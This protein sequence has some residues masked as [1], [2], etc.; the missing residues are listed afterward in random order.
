[1]KGKSKLFRKILLLS[2]SFISLSLTAQPR[3]PV[4]LSCGSMRETMWEN[5]LGPAILMDTLSDRKHL[6]GLGP[7]AYLKGEWMVY[8]GQA[9]YSRVRNDTSI[10]MSQG[11]SGGAPFFVYARVGEWKRT[12]LPDS[13]SD[14]KKLEAF[15]DDFYRD[16]DQPFP[17]R[18]EGRVSHAQFHVL[19]LPDGAPV[20]SP[21]DAHRSKV[22][23][24]LDQQ[25]CLM[26]G[27][28]SRKH[29]GIFTHHDSFIHAHLMTTDGLKMGH[30]EEAEWDPRS[31]TLFLPA[32]ML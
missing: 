16:R 4:V 19:N 17:F 30:L 27:F 2:I 20:Q 28:F 32:S 6:Y 31:L 1:M 29:Q 15:L 24:V 25:E 8:G 26:L 10:A 12:S 3:M 7:L 14:I 22:H 23:F 13:V 9:W 21:E 5:K 11:F 18:L